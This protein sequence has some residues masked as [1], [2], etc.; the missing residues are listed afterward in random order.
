MIS[1]SATLHV[2]QFPSGRYGFVGSVPKALGDI[3]P[4]T[5][6]DVMGGRAFRN[7]YGEIVTVKF[8][9]FSTEDEARDFASYH[10]FYAKA[11]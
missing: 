2:I 1:G 6:S 5:R 3:V 8:P 10:G 9:S 4:A 7:E 11:A